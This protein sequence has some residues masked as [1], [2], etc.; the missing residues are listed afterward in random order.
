M[1]YR[2]DEV[3]SYRVREPVK[4]SASWKAAE[5]ILGLLKQQQQQQT[6]NKYPA[7][8]FKNKYFADT[9][10]V[11]TK[12]NISEEMIQS[13][14]AV[15]PRYQ[16]RRKDEVQWQNKQNKQTDNNNNNNNKQRHKLNRHTNYNRGTALEWLVKTLLRS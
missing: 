10:T 2:I 14:I 16:K 6:I 9:Y 15:F 5:L 1:F 12:K 3:L 8:D 13:R 4:C 7:V 11:K